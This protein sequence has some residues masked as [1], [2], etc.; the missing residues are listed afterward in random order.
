MSSLEKRMA[1]H[2]RF[3]ICGDC[4]WCASYLDP[5]SVG[6]CPTCGSR[7]IED[8]PVS[9]NERYTFDQSPRGGVVLGFLP[10]P[11]QAA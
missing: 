2:V 10:L 6:E 8:M 3:L 5:R 1:M 9:A 4:F 7:M 11:A